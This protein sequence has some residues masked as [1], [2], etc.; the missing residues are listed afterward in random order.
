MQTQTPPGTPHWN[1][2]DVTVH[3]ID[4]ISLPPETG[5]WLLPDATPDVVAQ[6]PWLHTGFTDDASALR[7]DSHTFALTVGTL[8]VLVDTG[9]GNGKTRANPAWHDL[10]TDYLQRLTDAG[11]PPDSVDLV[12]LTHLHTDHVGWNTREENGAWLPTF[13]RARYVTSRAEREFWS[14]YAMDEPRQQM[15]RDSVHPVEDA[16]LLD[17]VDVPAEGAEVAPGI[18][19][20]PTP[21]HTPGHV[22]V[23]VHS[24]GASALITGD[25]LH[26]PV[27]LPHPHIGSCVDIDPGQAE[28]TRSD[29][30]ASLTDTETLLLG[31]HFPHPT[32]G[33]VVSDGDTYRLAP[34]PPS[35][36]ASPA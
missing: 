8:R 9:I 22:A 19:L 35:H 11:F 12:V 4:E 26:H 32:A 27:Q 18:R 25:L 20:V 3:R 24:N 15:F 21:G 34:V 23:E 16:G 17:L 33:R 2:G 31:T 5:P 13:P 1:V 10:R 29:L 7:L 14:G 6:H 28:A 36:T 30:L